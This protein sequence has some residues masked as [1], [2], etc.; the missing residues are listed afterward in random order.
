MRPRCA[1]DVLTDAD[2]AKVQRRRELPTRVIQAG[3]VLIQDRVIEPN[4]A[5]DLSPIELP[6]FVGKGPLQ[7]IPPLIVGRGLR[8]ERVRTPDVHAAGGRE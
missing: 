4:L 8:P 1:T 5:G 2:L 3:Q 6:S 7:Y